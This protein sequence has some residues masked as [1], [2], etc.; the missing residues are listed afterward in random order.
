MVYDFSFIG[1][2]ANR[3]RWTGNCT[4]PFRRGD[5]S[6]EKCV[7]WK[8]EG[9]CRLP[10]SPDV[11]NVIMELQDPD[12]YVTVPWMKTDVPE[13]DES[14]GVPLGLG[15]NHATVPNQGNQTGKEVISS[16]N[17]TIIGDYIATGFS[18]HDSKWLV[19][20]SGNYTFQSVLQKIKN[21]EITVHRRYI[22]VI[23]RHNQLCSAMKGNVMAMVQSLVT[24]IRRLSC[25]AKIFIDN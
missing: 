17:T 6:Y 10:P 11:R 23:L 1:T 25:M 9:R 12:K 21:N 4:T 24:E 2:I 22:F 18:K 5:R 13:V 15:Q 20:A 16:G 8:G 3:K 14:F 19:Q 7:D